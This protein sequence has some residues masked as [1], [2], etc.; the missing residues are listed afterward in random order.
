MEDYDV[1]IAGAGPTGMALGLWLTHQGIR[2]GIVDK[3]AEPGTTSRAMVVQARTLELYRQTGIAEE[4]AAEGAPA[5]AI[6]LWVRGR[7]KAHLSFLAAGGDVTPYPFVL[8]YPQDRHERLLERRLRLAGVDVQRHTELVDFDDRGG[9]VVARL[10]TPQGEREC[11]A[12]FLAGC[13]GARSFVRHKLGAGFPGGTY[14][15]LFYVADVQIGGMETGS[16][17]HASLDTSDFL[18]LFPYTRDGRARLIGTIRD[19]RT[20]AGKQPDDLSFE[21]VSHK[22]ME[23]LGV[24][25]EQVH[26][27]STYRTHHRVT[28]RYRH[29]QVFL[30]G[31]AA[32]V[33]SP[34]GGQG[35]NTGIGDA[36]NLAWKLADV[37]RGDASDALLDSYK[38]ERLAFAR[39][40]VDTTDRAFT[41][42][43]AEGGFADFVRMHIAPTVANAAYSFE[44]AREFVFRTISQTTIHYH[45]SPLSDG[46]A[47]KVK[48][49]D[50]LPWAMLEGQDN[51]AQ[52]ARIGWQVHV[53]GE[54]RSALRDWCLRHGLPVQV[55]PWGAVHEQAG[56]ERNAVY[57]VRPDYYVGLSD[58]T[59]SCDAIAG[60]FADRGYRRFA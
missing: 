55:F 50:R 15:H 44:A 16:E 4:V 7:R 42:I 41:F 12:R 33:H 49:G 11:T 39:R 26:W 46:T 38:T 17:V 29:G 47:G 3:A 24:K 1:L 58:P 48:G 13:D 40:L 56:F 59:A 36:I 9:Q 23:S 18:L 21:D 14:A 35:M 22:A 52:P 32:H 20:G 2:V 53:Y 54:A 43:T 30:L 6:N 60:Y 10:H 45:D 31:D 34:A 27:F 57:L 51:H 28:D 5:E 8:I 37:L 19:E 25:V